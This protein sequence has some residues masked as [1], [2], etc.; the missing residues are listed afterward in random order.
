MKLLK[1][2]GLAVLIVLAILLVIAIF[3]PSHVRIEESTIINA[4]VNMV[5]TKVNHLKM[6]EKWSPFQ[7]ADP[8][9]TSV[10]DGPDEGVGATQ[11]WKSEVNHDG[12]MTI[13][14]SRRDE[15]IRMKLDFMENGTAWSDWKFEPGNKVTKVS[16]SVEISD[17]P[18]PIGRYIGLFM[19]ATMKETFSEGLLNLKKLVEDDYAKLMV[20]R[21]GEITLDEVPAWQGIAVL[22]SGKCSQITERYGLAMGEVRK[23]VQEHQIQVTGPD[24]AV[25]PLWDVKADRFKMAAGVPVAK[26]VTVSGPVRYFEYPACKVVKVTHYGSYETLT[27]TYDAAIKYIKDHNLQ[28][29]GA[30]WEVYITNPAT[31]QDITKWETVVY[32]PVK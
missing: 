23:F 26:K 16:W 6:W 14:E 30:P 3:L 25:Y 21:T 27:A 10:Y 17:L 31:Q 13:V 15:Y 24:Y 22:D 11:K 32:H 4:P 12:S 9:M 7:K 2:V 1:R 19:N 8:A 20:F 28:S 5:F 18:Y 29:A